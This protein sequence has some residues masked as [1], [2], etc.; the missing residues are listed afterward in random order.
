M[1]PTVFGTKHLSLK[2]FIRSALVTLCT[3]FVVQLWDFT[4]DIGRLVAFKFTFVSQIFGN[5]GP[6]YISLLSTRFL[7]GSLCRRRSLARRLLTMCAVVM[8]GIVL[9]VVA[10]EFSERLVYLWRGQPGSGLG[11]VIDFLELGL[12]SFFASLFSS[13]WLLL[14]VTTGALLRAGLRLPFGIPLLTRRFDIEKKP[15]Q[16][17]GL[18]AGGIVAICY[19]GWT[20]LA[21]IL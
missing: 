13:I 11:R 21:A 18:M 12:A 3:L 10:A 14:L 2:C 15:L 19:W 17:I 16:C 6:D 1:I 7:V 8:I 9:A 5:V 4:G 20:A